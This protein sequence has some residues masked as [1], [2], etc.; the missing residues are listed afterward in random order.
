MITDL[1]ALWQEAFRESG[2]G[3]FENGFSQ[4]RFRRLYGKDGLAGA[5][6]W[7]DASWDGRKYAYIYGLATAKVYRNQG[8]GKRL[9]NQTHQQLRRQGYAGVILVPA[10]RELF[11]Y[12][13]KLGY[14]DL[15]SVEEFTCAAAGNTP[16][17]S[18]TGKEY[19]SLRPQDAVNQETCLSYLQSYA[20]FWTGEG[21]MLCG[22]IHENKLYVQEFWGDPD[23]APAITASLGAKEGFF[24]IPGNGRPF[25]MYYPLTD[26]PKPTYFGIA[27]D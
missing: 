5:V 4:D 15:C 16:V 13:E 20:S 18:L 24:R 27:M 22:S 25:A 6:Y 23:L 26:A 14:S 19:F 10:S 1:K 12:Y 3:F 7:F 9:M 21:W 17:K 8:Y 11:G 2:D